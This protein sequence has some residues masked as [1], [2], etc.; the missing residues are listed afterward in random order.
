MM[1]PYWQSD[2]SSKTGGTMAKG[3]LNGSAERFAMALRDMVR[4]AAAEAVEPLKADVATLKTDVA[5]LKTDVA[6]LR[7]HTDEQFTQLRSDMENGFAELR[8]PK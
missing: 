5:N 2:G 7:T 8:P 4:E 6:D 1:V 3:K